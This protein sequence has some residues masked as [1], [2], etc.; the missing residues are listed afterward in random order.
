MQAKNIGQERRTRVASYSQKP[1]EIKTPLYYNGNFFL[2]LWLSQNL[3]QL[4]LLW[5]HRARCCLKKKKSVSDAKNYEGAEFL[6]WEIILK[7]LGNKLFGIVK[8][9]KEIIAV[10]WSGK[11]I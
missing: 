9:I 3:K 7:C 11:Q 2:S 5:G 10:V 1:Q 6:L 8:L 4:L